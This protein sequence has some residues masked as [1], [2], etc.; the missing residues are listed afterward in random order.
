MRLFFTKLIFFFLFSCF[1][2]IT[3]ICFWGSVI[4]KKFQFNILYDIGA[5]GHINTRLKEVEK[6]K[7]VEILFLGSSHAYRGFDTRL[8]RKEGF[9]C[10]NL[11]SSSQTPI[12]TELLLERHLKQLNPKVIIFDV[13]ASSFCSDGIESTI[14][15]ISNSTIDFNSMLMSLKVKNLKVINTFIFSL[16]QDLFHQKEKFTE[17]KIIGKDTY[18]EGGFVERKLEFFHQKKNELSN[19]SIEKKD[20][21]FNEEQFLAFERIIKQAKQKGI[22]VFLVHSPY[23]SQLYNSKSNNNEFDKRIEKYA[24]Y[25]NFNK[26]SVFN[27]SLDFYDRDHLNQNGVVKYNKL[28]M[29]ILEL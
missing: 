12:Q 23:T 19:K 11:G 16:F 5:Y 4:P 20:W 29:E 3:L 24:K 21:K 10:F 18:I 7:N 15:I 27:D 9:T 28:L 26:D 6:T 14:D 1:F 13:Y 8:Y 17:N 25:Y 22:K 2:Y